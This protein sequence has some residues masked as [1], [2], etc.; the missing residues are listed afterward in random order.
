MRNRLVKQ[1]SDVICDLEVIVM[2][3]LKTIE[4][5]WHRTYLVFGNSTIMCR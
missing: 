2:V 3:Y 5:H 1:S 4:K